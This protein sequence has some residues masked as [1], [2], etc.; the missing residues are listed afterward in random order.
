MSTPQE[1]QQPQEPQPTEPSDEPR[2][3]DSQHYKQTAPAPP[4]V[5]P[6]PAGRRPSAAW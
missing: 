6:T 5:S 3:E 2:T 1:P 4:Y